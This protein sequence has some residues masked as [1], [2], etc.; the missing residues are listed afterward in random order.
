MSQRLLRSY[1]AF[2]VG[3]GWMHVILFTLLG[4]IPWYISVGQPL[5][6][7]F[8]WK[9]WAVYACPA[10]GLLVGA[11]FGFGHFVLSG[12]IQVFLDQRDLLEELLQTHRQLLDLLQTWQ[13][14]GRRA[15]RDPFDL[16]DLRTTDQQLL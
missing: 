6:G 10:I 13:P 12:V 9:Q 14:A 5:S 11:L 16:T 4:F 15:T 7:E 8:Q 2:L 1:A 3:L